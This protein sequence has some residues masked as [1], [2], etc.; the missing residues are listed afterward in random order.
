MLIIAAT[1]IGNSHDAT[2][3]LVDA[4][5]QSDIIA[6]EDTR[7]CIELAKRLDLKLNAQIISL[8]DHN[9]SQKIDYLISELENG[10][11][12]LQIS[13]AGM[14]VISDPGYRLVGAAIKNGIE[15]T[16]LPGPSAVLN[17][18]V[19]S[20]MPS[21][22]FF[23]D[24]FLPNKKAGRIKRLTELKNLKT[25]LIFFESPFRIAKTVD[26]I[27]E[28]YGEDVEISIVREMTKKYEEVIKAR[29]CEMQVKIKN[30][31]PKGEICLLVNLHVL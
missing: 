24:G 2:F 26:D 3:R 1:P 31:E 14:P 6:A 4:L 20:N 25:T 23:F 21:H 8:N 7:K 5:K 28:V 16:C 22:N 15:Y 18:L 19:L 10:K 12:V 27:I 11:T 29:A 17:A 30:K 13:D 9:E